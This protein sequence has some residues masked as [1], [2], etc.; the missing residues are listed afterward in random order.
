MKMKG[1]RCGTAGIMWRCLKKREAAS[2]PVAV[3]IDE[4]RTSRNCCWC[5]TAILDGVNGARDNNVLV[6]KACNALWERDVNA[7][8]NIMEISL[9]IW[10]GLGKP[11]AYSRG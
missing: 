5:E 2:D 8:K 10:K 9:A 6:C 7:A 4:F 3:P 11:E 1:L